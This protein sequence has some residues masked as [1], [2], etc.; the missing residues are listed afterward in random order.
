MAENKEYFRHIMLLYFQKGKNASQT[1]KKI[2]TLYDESA[3]DDSTCRKWF[4]KFRE[5]NFNVSDARSGRP[6]E[7]DGNEILALI[8]SDRHRTRKIPIEKIPSV[9]Q[10]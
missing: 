5:N 10:H 8:E 7:T 4:R 2:C 3:V 9:K 1:Q 6:A